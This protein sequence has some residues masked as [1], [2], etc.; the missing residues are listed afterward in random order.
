[1]I[2]PDKKNHLQSAS[3]QQ[4]E[5]EIPKRQKKV[6][7]SYMITLHCPTNA[8]LINGDAFPVHGP[9]A[10]APVLLAVPLH[11]SQPS[12]A[13]QWVPERA[14]PENLAALA[15]ALESPRYR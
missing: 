8:K 5:D 2:R 14:Q 13:T 11:C 4:H 7:I 15:S 9:Y 6:L 12:P 3:L 10:L 1:M